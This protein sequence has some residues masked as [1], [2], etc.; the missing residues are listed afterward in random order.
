MPDRVRH[1]PRRSVGKSVLL[2]LPILVWSLLMFS[3]AMI[4]PG[5]APKLAAATPLVFMVAL[6]FHRLEKPRLLD[7]VP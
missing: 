5:R 6:F 7:A 2:T 1:A 4:E 3:R